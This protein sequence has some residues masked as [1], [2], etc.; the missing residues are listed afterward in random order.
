MR[1]LVDNNGSRC[2][3]PAMSPASLQFSWCSSTC[4]PRSVSFPFD[5]AQACRWNRLRMGLL[6]CTAPPFSP[7][8]ARWHASATMIVWCD[9]SSCTTFTGLT[10][11]Q[12]S[13]SANPQ[14]DLFCFLDS[15]TVSLCPKWQSRLNAYKSIYRRLDRRHEI[16]ANAIVRLV[17]KTQRQGVCSRALPFLEYQSMSP[18]IRLLP[19]GR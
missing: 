12:F 8:Y 2:N 9:L 17:Y 19:V 14:T 18:V 4:Q 13:E 16:H 10:S 7:T 11:L 5:G 15:D 1:K 3:V 6:L